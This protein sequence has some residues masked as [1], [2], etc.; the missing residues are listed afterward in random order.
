MMA[1]RIEPMPPKIT[2]ARI[3]MDCTSVK[4]SGLTNSCLAAKTTP[5]APEKA[6]P[7]AK[8]MSL[9][10]SRAMPMARAATSSSRM[11]T[12]A[13]PSGESLRRTL[14]RVTSPIN[15]STRR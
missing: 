14:T 9:V 12:Q 7:V 10:R 15:T 5:M 13:R 4:D 11:A 8:A 1:P 2:M 6:A 3:R